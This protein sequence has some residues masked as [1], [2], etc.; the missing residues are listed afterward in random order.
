MIQ[1][2]K[3]KVKINKLKIYIQTS[4]I[5]IKNIIDFLR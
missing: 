5:E 1:K 4:K 3:K 2:I